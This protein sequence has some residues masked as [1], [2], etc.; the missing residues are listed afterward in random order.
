MEHPSRLNFSF[1][2]ER[3]ERF[4]ATPELP[5]NR[6]QQEERKSEDKEIRYG[7]SVQEEILLLLGDMDGRHIYHDQDK[8]GSNPSSR[9]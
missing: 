8:L 6:H 7:K 1:A 4:K 5:R 9:A 2:P 3:I